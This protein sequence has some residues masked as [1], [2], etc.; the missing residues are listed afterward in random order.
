[1]AVLIIS[2][3][4]ARGYIGASAQ[5]IALEHLGQQVW[6][7]PTI[8]LS[9]HPGHETFSGHVTPPGALASMVQALDQNG[10]LADVEGVITGYM[11]SSDH[12]AIAAGAVNRVREAAPWA[13]HLCDPAFGDGPTGL[14]VEESA[15]EAIKLDLI[16]KADIATPNIFELEWLTGRPLSSLAETLTAAKELG[17]ERVLTTSAPATQDGQIANLL[18]SG[19]STWLANVARRARAPHGT[20]DLIAGLFLAHLIKTDS[21]EK[22]L[23]LACAGV[24]AALES[25]GEADELQLTDTPEAWVNPTPWPLVALGS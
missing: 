18:I 9:S 19:K 8:Q 21:A 7:L 1:M 16:P 2:S 22:A 6:L 17:P 4:V 23:A 5:R 3:Q 12:A 15:A 11:P 25:T 10:W 14:Y 13:L 20:G 24:D